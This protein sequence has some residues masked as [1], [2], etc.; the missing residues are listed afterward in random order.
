MC[1]LNKLN[2]VVPIEIEEL[3]SKLDEVRT[4]DAKH[5]LFEKHTPLILKAIEKVRATRVVVTPK[6]GG[7]TRWC[8]DK[9]TCMDFLSKNT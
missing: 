1:C 3:C 4:F 6:L 5:R 7:V 2:S 8:V 9:F